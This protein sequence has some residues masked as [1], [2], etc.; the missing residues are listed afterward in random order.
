M[1]YEI[2][3]GPYHPGLEEPYKL[4]M[5]CEGETVKDA[6]LHIGFNFRGIEH[7]AETRNYIQVIALMERVCGICSFIHTLTLCQ[8]ME[9]LTG[10]TAPP[11]A[12]YIRVVMGELERLHSH[13]LWAGIAAKLMGFKTMFMTCFEIR[14]KVMDVL[15]AISGNRVNYAMNCVGGVNRDVEDPQSILSMVDALEKE[16]QKTII[17][18]FTTSKTATSRCAGIGVLTTEKARSLGVVGPVARA[19]GIGQ[20]LRKEAPYAAYAEM[21]FDVPVV[22][23]GDVR[24]RL[25]VR[26]LEIMESCKILRQALTKMPNGELVCQDSK[27]NFLKLSAST[28]T[29]R[30]EA[31]RGEVM[32]SVSWKEGSRMPSRVH[33]RTPTYVNMPSVRFMVQGARLADTPL[34]QASV[35]PCYSCTDR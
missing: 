17:P 33:V 12:Q 28:A 32:Y 10:Q 29:A 24:A 34:I 20:D 15:Q 13:V 11:R 25:L 31:P 1:S 19:S 4:D 8:A 23:D 22:P 6:K 2:P 9:K 18:I 35:D 21:D 16:M 30:V 27:F 26:A 14:E 7:L 3:M 5:I